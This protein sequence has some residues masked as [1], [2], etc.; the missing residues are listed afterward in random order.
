MEDDFVAVAGEIARGRSGE[1]HASAGGPF[2]GTATRRA[3]ERPA[4]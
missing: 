2:G 3:S 4:A 1:D